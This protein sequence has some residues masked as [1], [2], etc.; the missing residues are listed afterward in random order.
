[1]TTVVYLVPVGRERYEL[2]SEA[3][4]PGEVGSRAD[5]RAGR[6]LRAARAKWAAAV[7]GAHAD[8]VRRGWFA[9]WRDQVICRLAERVAEQHALWVLRHAICATAVYPCDL[10]DARA[11]AIVRALLARARQFHRRWI[12]VDAMLLLATGVLAPVPGPNVLAYY[13]AFRVLGHYL[14][15]RG[16]CQALDQT[17]W[18]GRAEPALA[19]LGQLVALPRETREARVEAIAARLSLPRLSAFFRRAAVPER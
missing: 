10:E 18:S 1:M 15:W 2:Y 14:S 6:A 19:E 9:R 7:H 8:D 13:F 4:E 11:L 12:F 3:T 16:A 17:V 5:G